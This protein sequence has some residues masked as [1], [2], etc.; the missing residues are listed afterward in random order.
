MPVP[1]LRGGRQFDGQCRLSSK[2][3]CHYV[4]H[5]WCLKVRLVFLTPPLELM[6]N[7]VFDRAN[8]LWKLALFSHWVSPNGQNPKDAS[9]D[10]AA[11]NIAPR[12][13]PNTWIASFLPTR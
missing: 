11:K 5:L 6:A 7:F 9:R 13:R 10:F 4:E 1:Q 8:Q 3:G 12:R 2:E